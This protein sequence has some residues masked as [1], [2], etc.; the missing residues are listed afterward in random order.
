MSVFYTQELIKS[1]DLH[2]LAHF[3][4]H[5][6]SQG[7]KQVL[8]RTEENPS[9]IFQ[10]PSVREKGSGHLF[11]QLPI[12]LQKNK[13]LWLLSPKANPLPLTVLTSS[14]SS[15]PVAPTPCT[16]IFHNRSLLCLSQPKHST[17]NLCS[18]HSL[19]AFAHAVPSIRD[20]L[21]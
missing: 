19:C 13:K 2:C 11:F 3:L 10:G 14:F 6:T 8:S 21:A 5:K 20:M 15:T 18:P 17:C 7:D 4:S 9:Q 16:N 1:W 12:F